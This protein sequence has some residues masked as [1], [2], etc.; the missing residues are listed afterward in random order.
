MT[1][2]E[3]FPSLKGKETLFYTKAQVEVNCV[4]RQ[5]VKDAINKACKIRHF[6][7]VPVITIEEERTQAHNI[8]EE[9]YEVLELS[10]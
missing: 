2:K 6:N 7:G 4:D 9:L 8:L 3:E 10:Y 1:F 5:R